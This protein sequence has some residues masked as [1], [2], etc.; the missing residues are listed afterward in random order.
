MI[1]QNEILIIIIKSKIKHHD[2]KER[3]N[4][5]ENGKTWQ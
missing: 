2:T 5:K 1:R 3:K 4:V